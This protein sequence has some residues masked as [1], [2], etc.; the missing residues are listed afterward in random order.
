MT[1]LCEC[2]C[3]QQTRIAPRNRTAEGWIKGQPLRFVRGHVPAGARERSNQ[4][5]ATPWRERVIENS[6]GCLVFQGSLNSRGYGLIGRNLAHR[7]VWEAEHGPIPD[8]LTI[9]H[10]CQEKRCLNTAHMEVVTRAENTRRRWYPVPESG[11]NQ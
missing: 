4:E 3:G 6:R 7:H 11:D 1:G 8:G 9:D 2:G 5:R 10:R